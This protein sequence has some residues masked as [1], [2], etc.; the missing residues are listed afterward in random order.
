M[1]QSGDAPIALGRGD[2]QAQIASSEHITQWSGKLSALPL[3]MLP[4]SLGT[5]AAMFAI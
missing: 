2:L 5:P 3:R 1:I 4:W